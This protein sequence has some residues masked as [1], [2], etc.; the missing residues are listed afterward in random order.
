LNWRGRVIEANDD[1]AMIYFGAYAPWGW[2]ITTPSVIVPL[3]VQM[4][5]HLF[6]PL[7]LGLN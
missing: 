1:T 5:C 4:A 3:A 6:L 2:T 7:F